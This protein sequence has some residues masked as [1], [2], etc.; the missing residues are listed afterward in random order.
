MT[1]LILV[2]AD[3][4]VFYQKITTA[5]YHSNLIDSNLKSNSTAKEQ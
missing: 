4:D 3:N 5:N 2:L 1:I